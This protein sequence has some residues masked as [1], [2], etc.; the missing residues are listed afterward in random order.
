MLT[1]KCKTVWTVLACATVVFS[2]WAQQGPPT[3]VK[4]T[5]AVAMEMAPTRLV[6]AYSKA[7]FITTIQAESSGRVIELADTGESLLQGE[8]MGL[9]AD[10]AYALRLSELRGSMASQ[11][12]QVDFLKS[13]SVRLK[14]L[15]NQNLTSG[16]ALDQNKADLKTAQADLEQAQ[17]RF[18]Q[19]ESDISKLTPKAPFNAFVTRQIAQPGQF[20]SKGADLLEIMSADEVEILA[21]LPFKLKSVIQVGDVWQYIDEAGNPHQAQVDR[22]IPA[23]TSNSRQIQVHLADLSGDLLPGE[24]IQL[25]VPESLPQP[26]TAV[27][28]DALVLRRGGAHIFTIN[29]AGL[30]TKVS[31]NTGLAQGDL[32]AVEGAVA[33]GDQVVIRG[34][35]RL[36]DQQT[37]QVMNGGAQ[38]PG[39]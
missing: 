23:A 16:T 19:L 17:S 21:Q 4:T 18:K 24:P 3:F 5:T 20:L 29:D 35:E 11:Q 7:R 38:A 13:E 2:A 31:V 6:A 39:Q 36:R 27:P 33:A 37:V 28:R 32:I 26:V 30:A 9:I 14:S 10:E 8:A 25:M 12:A 15:E 34:N 1:R 22:F